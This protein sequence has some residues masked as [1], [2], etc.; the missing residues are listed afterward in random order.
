MTSVSVSGD[1][2]A[3]VYLRQCV[4]GPYFSN[5]VRIFQLGSVF[6]NWGPYSCG[7]VN[8]CDGVKLWRCKCL[9]RCAGVQYFNGGA[10]F[11]V[12]G[13]ARGVPGCIFFNCGNS[14]FIH[15]YVHYAP[16]NQV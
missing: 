8:I 13:T 11:S 14:T 16:G 2:M 3:P 9:W 15:A 10:Y 4:W 7:G 1:V 5:G 6:V 12:A